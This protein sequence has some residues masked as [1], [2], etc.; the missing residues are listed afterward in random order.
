MK[1]LLF[2]FFVLLSYLMAAQT[3]SIPP[4]PDLDSPA[5]DS[6]ELKPNFKQKKK[7][8][9]IPIT[10]KDYKIISSV[11]DTTF[12]DTTL[13]IQK[14]Y[15]Y[16]VLRR[17]DF[18]LMP[19]ANVGQPYN[20]LGRSLEQSLPIPGIGARAKHFGYLEADDIDYYHVPTPLTELMFK[21]TFE[22]GQFLDAL[23]TLN[24]SERLNLSIA[25]TGFRSLGK[26]RYEQAEWGRFRTTFNY[27]TQNNRYWARGHFAAQDLQSEESGGLSRKEAQFESGEEDFLDRSRLDVF[28]TNANSRIVGWRYHLDH[29]FNLVRPKRDSVKTRKTRVALG[30]KFQYETRFFQFTQSS[31][32]TI[33]AFGDPY[34]TP[35]NDK[36]KLQ[37]TQNELSA[38]FSNPQWGHLKGELNFFNYNYFFNSLLIQDQQTIANQLR[39]DEILLGASY[40]NTIGPLNIKGR[41]RYGL[42]GDMTGNLLDASATYGFGEHNKVYASVHGSSRMPNFNFLLYQ[43]DYQNFNWQNT[44]VFE[45]QRVQSITLGADFKWFGDVSAKYTAMDNYTYFAS[46][47][48]PEDIDA[49]L[50]TAFVKPFQE[51]GT[52]NY[53][54]VKWK[55]EFSW[56][57]W[58]LNNTVLF[59]EVTQDNQV[60]NLPQL[61]TRNTLYFSSDVFDKAM[62]LQTGVTFKYFTAYSMD[63]YNPLLG[64]FYIQNNEEL[65]AYPLID[66]FINAKVRR[67]RI[68]FKAEHLNTIWG[69]DYNYYAAPNYPY[70]DFVIRFGLVWN[71]L[72]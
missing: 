38:L 43:S 2:T 55:K 40:Q 72:S 10:I 7:A 63:A 56:R 23:L 69:K 46:E 13:T 1:Q 32:P 71:F 65:G 52:I 62:F 58:A 48:T 6:L 45:K 3:D 60:L 5:K 42:S 25:Y 66:V 16:N 47:A 61:L 53:L 57:K 34:V 11:G 19:F 70:R 51:P 59:Q 29:Q 4:R 26:Y 14:E 44:G 17:D 41:L 27:R 49:D 50:E 15:K 21:T 67:T 20:F 12:L 36:S 39:G 28:Y 18:E 54:R 9:A 64:E 31:L 35:I 33:K 30:H 37:V 22:Q 24:T 68:Y 8:E